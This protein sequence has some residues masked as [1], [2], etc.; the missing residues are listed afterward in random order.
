MSLN[1]ALQVFAENYHP[2]TVVANCAVN[3]F[4]DSVMAHFKKIVQ[5][6]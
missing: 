5:R 2:D 3:V 4:N 1:S 6:R